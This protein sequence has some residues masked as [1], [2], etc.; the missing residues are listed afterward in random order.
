MFTMLTFTDTTFS[1]PSVAF[2]PFIAVFFGLLIVALFFQVVGALD[3]F[4]LRNSVQVIAVGAFQIL[5]VVFSFIQI[6]EIVAYRKCI[7]DYKSIGF[8]TTLT[9]LE[10]SRAIWQLEESR[11]TFRTINRINDTFYFGIGDSATPAPRNLS[12]VMDSN[13]PYLQRSFSLSISVSFFMIVFAVLNFFA[14]RRAVE[15]YGW[16][17]FHW[18]G[19]DISKREILR[20]YHTFI[21]LL[22]A[23]IF[24]SLG[25]VFLMLSAIYYSRKVE[26]TMTSPPAVSVSGDPNAH[27]NAFKSRVQAEVDLSARLTAIAGS[28]V[29]IIGAVFYSLAYYGVQRGSKLLMHLF[30]GLM[31]LNICVVLFTLFEAIFDERY[32]VVKIWLASFGVVQLSLNITTIVFAVLCMRDFSKGLPDM[33]RE[34]GAFQGQDELERNKREADEQLAQQCAARARRSEARSRASSASPNGRRSNAASI[35]ADISQQSTDHSPMNSPKHSHVLLKVD[36]ARTGA[37]GRFQSAKSSA[38]SLSLSR[39]S[40]AIET[41]TQAHPTERMA[42]T[43]SA[44]TIVAEQQKQSTQ[45][46]PHTGY[47]MT[48]E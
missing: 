43:A 34:L 17:I 8:S 25:I 13:M 41:G 4:L 42:V 30:M 31:L 46:P 40:T 37:H 22:K 14:S 9:P 20:R 44:E 2:S 28:V 21:V 35:G 12:L 33:A 6:Q 26:I 10:Q 3:A 38:P 19:A 15:A 48:I 5:T 29:V 16:S 11:C 39:C 7:D 36:A 45:Q 23:N 24:F 47:R 18:Q 1:L 27:I 32:D